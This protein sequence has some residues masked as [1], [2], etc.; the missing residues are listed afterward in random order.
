MAVGEVLR[1][2]VGKCLL[3]HPHVVEQ[4]KG[5]Q[6]VQLGVGVPMAC[7]II[8]HGLRRAVNDL[9]VNGDWAILQVDVSNAFNTVA[10]SAI[11]AGARDFAPAVIP[12]MQFCYSRT[13]PLF[14]GDQVIH[15]STGTHQGCPMG[16]LGFALGIQRALRSTAAQAPLSWM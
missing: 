9:P 3:R 12:W 7:P 4:V 5:L 2:V 8:A 10:R 14:S 11:M 1:R 13:V 16:P 6:P 15:S